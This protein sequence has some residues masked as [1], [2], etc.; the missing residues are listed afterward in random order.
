MTVPNIVSSQ[1]QLAII[2]DFNSDNRPAMACSDYISA[3]VAILFSNRKRTFAPAV[4][5]S[6]GSS[7]VPISREPSDFNNENILDIV[8][9]SSTADDIVIL[10]EVGDGT[11]L[12]GSGSGPQGLV[13]SDFNKDTRLD[14][15]VINLVAKNMAVFLADDN[16]PFGDAQPYETGI[17]SQ[18]HW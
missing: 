3:K 4:F 10:N 13:V 16:E 9:V 6:P 1:P 2:T 17:E 7:S 5:Y 11:F 12:V 14:I 18:L 15:A 8:V